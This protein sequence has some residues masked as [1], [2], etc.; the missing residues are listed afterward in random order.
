[1]QEGDLVE[2]GTAAGAPVRGRLCLA[3]Q[4]AADVIGVEP[5]TLDMLAL[6]PGDAVW[7]R[8]VKTLPADWLR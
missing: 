7:M 1:M 6:K 8:P 2:I 5:M 4:L 3:D